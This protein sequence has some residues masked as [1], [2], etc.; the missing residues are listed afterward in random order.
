MEKSIEVAAGPVTQAINLI[1][2]EA[3]SAT[4]THAAP[5]AP[6]TVKEIKTI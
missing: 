6:G 4:K 3:E 5:K 2:T 1:L